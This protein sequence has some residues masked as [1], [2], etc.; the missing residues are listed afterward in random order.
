VPLQLPDVSPTTPAIL[1]AELDLDDALVD[2]GDYTGL[3]ADGTIAASIIQG[4]DL[5][6]AKLGPLT[7]S[8]VSLRQV[9]LSNASLQRLT[10]RRTE[11]RTCRAIGL[12]V[13]FDH[14]SD[15][16][17]MDCRLD[18]ATIH[19][20]KVKG[21]AVFTGCSFRETTI[22]GDLSNTRFVDCD[23]IETEFRATRATKCDFRSSRLLS[24]RGLLSL[25]GATI[26]SEQAVSACLLIAAEAGLIVD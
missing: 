5:S 22:G 14:A 25:R 13:S 23:F 1:E 26:S 2:G 20:E 24:A 12:R 3:V 4:V 17:I 11:W 7:L 18:Y 21:G 16:S 15:L 8:N 19:L 10:A 9:D 6:R